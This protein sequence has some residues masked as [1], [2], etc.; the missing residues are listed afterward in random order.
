MILFYLSSLSC[1]GSAVCKKGNKNTRSQ[2]RSNPSFIYI[3]T[4]SQQHCSSGPRGCIRS[5]GLNL[6]TKCTRALIIYSF[7]C[8]SVQVF[9]LCNF[10]WDF[11]L[12]D[13]VL[14]F[15]RF[16]FFFFFFLPFPFF[17][18]V[19]RLFPSS[20]FTT[21]ILFSVCLHPSLSLSPYYLSFTFLNLCDNNT[22][23]K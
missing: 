2:I 19:T 10:I 15:H 4:S 18:Q 16:S 5:V 20:L 6:S 1:F 11:L 9:L 22:C 17:V 23:K 12:L 21:P 14:K 7:S 8:T 3:E 13:F